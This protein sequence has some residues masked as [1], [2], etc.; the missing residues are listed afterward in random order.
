M[1]SRAERTFADSVQAIWSIFDNL[2]FS[3]PSPKIIP[4]VWSDHHNH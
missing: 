3:I 2:S 4:W 1:T